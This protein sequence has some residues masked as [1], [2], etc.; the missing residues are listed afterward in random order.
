MR[1]VVLSPRDPIPV[2]TGLSERIYQLCRHLGD[3]HTVRVLFPHEPHRKR[4]ESGRMPDDRPFER[5]RL[6]SRVINVLERRVPGY[7]AVK[8]VYKLHPWLYPGVRAEFLE[9]DPDAL[10]VE[11]PFLVPLALG[12]SRGIDAPIVLTEHNVQYKITERLGIP[13]TRLMRQFEVGMIK[14]VDAVATVS[15]TDHATLAEHVPAK[16]VVVAPNGVDTD[17]YSSALKRGAREIRRRHE[18]SEPVFIYHGSLGNAQNGEAVDRLL[19]EVFPQLRR[20]YPDAS[21]LLVGANPPNRT[22]QGVVCTG[23]V[24]ELPYY[25]AAAD[26]ATV[27]LRSGSG[28]K[29]KILEYLATGVPVVTTTIGAEGLPIEHGEHALIADRTDRFVRETLRATRDGD[30]RDRLTGRGR[31]LVESQFSWDRTLQS[32]NDILDELR[33]GDTCDRRIDI[34]SKISSK[35]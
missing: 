19:G 20:R 35:I 11:M 9:F 5:V 12:A 7:S 21:L 24:D 4:T 31:E 1:I 18:L 32:Y 15:E 34:G 17:R 8:G 33:A 6:P 22:P 23:L 2:Y 28:T 30:L 27:P 16:R 13:G 25:L 14:Q 26:V 10:V 3:E 29:L